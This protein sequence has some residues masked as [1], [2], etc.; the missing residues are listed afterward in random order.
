LFFRETETG[1]SPLI[2]SSRSIASEG[3]D[4]RAGGCGSAAGGHVLIK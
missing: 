2:D 1:S 3:L 4:G